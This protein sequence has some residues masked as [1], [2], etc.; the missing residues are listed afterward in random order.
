MDKREILRLL[1][2]HKRGEYSA[3]RVMECLKDLPYRDLGS[4]KI[5]FHR[6]LRR[7]FPE[8]I[9]SPGKTREQM[10]A[11]IGETLRR[12]GEVFALR[13]EEETGIFL[14]NRFPGLEYRKEAKALFSIKGKRK[15]KKSRIVV[16]SA[17]T[18]DI[19][20]AEEAALTCEMFGYEPERIWDVGVAGV[21]RLFSFLKILRRATAVV[22]VAGMDGVL[23]ALV[24]GLIEAPVIAVPTSV[25]YGSHWKG[26]APL[27]AMLN[28]CSPGVAVVN[29]DNGFGAG[30]LAGLIQRQK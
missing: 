19:P 8:V 26:L 20:V 12:K 13:L 24:A 15:P 1:K 7:G 29:I 23:P 11:I 14:K 6:K 28:S 10:A 21:H 4:A 17:G 3:R 5:D 9:F 27:L 16:L 22:A 25:G 30:Y 2:K 18:S